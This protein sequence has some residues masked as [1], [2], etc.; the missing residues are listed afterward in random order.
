VGIGGDSASGKDTLAGTLI[1][2]LGS[3][4]TV[5]LHGDD[6]HRWPRGHEAWNSQTHL[7]PRSNYF[8]QPIEHIQELK[9]GGSIHKSEYDHARG[10]FGPP[11]VVH[12]NRFIVFDGL[13][14]FVFERMRSVFDIKIFLATHEPLRQHWKIQRDM[15][16]RGH[17]REKVTAEI[18]RRQ[19]DS[20][21]YIQPQAAF[22]D[23]VI[24]YL[25]L[26]PVDG[27][28]S[29]ALVER[30]PLKVRHRL[31][32]AILHMEALMD[33]LSNH[34]TSL[35]LFWSMEQDLHRQVFEVSGTLSAADVESIA[36]RIFPNVDDYLGSRP[37]WKADLSGICQ[38]VFLVL[39]MHVEETQ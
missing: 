8:R 23:W 21:R 30:V 1:S 27:G 36:Y 29:G 15:Q 17:A 26:D 3:R 37:A 16:S 18:E 39:L 20:T 24:E 32:S 6:Y 4:D 5:R 35:Q 11:A 25:P 2:F 10:E 22:A 34:K 13:H 38:L 9:S 28:G 31:S 33:Q 12:P 14:P 19:T 7:D